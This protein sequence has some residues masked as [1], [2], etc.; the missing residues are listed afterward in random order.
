MTFQLSLH[1]GNSGFRAGSMRER[2]RELGA[3][4]YGTLAGFLA[5]GD[6]RGGGGRSAVRVT[7]DVT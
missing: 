4:L 7:A 5:P 6:G 2:G 1:D 3:I